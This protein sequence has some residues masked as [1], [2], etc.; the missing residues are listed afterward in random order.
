MLDT[1]E[2]PKGMEFSELP[3]TWGIFI[4]ENDIYG[5]GHPLYHVERIVRE[6]QRPFDDGCADCRSDPTPDGRGGAA[7]IYKWSVSYEKNYHLSL[8]MERAIISG[9][10]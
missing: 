3:E 7:C 4:T 9:M 6:L 5:A 1:C 2:L 8:Y 10:R